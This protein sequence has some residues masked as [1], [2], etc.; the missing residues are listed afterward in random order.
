M[1]RQ[2]V[3]LGGGT[4]VIEGIQKGL[5]EKIKK[6]FTVGLN[7]SHHFFNSSFLMYVDETFANNQKY[8]LEKLPLV[9]G[10]EHSGVSIRPNTIELPGTTDYRRDCSK[11]V[12]RASL[13][14]IFALSFMIYALDEGDIFL[15]GYDYGAQKGSGKQGRS[16]DAH[17]KALTHWY[18]KGGLK[19]IYTGKPQQ[20]SHRGI[21]KVNW[22]EA[23]HVGE[24]G[25]L[26]MPRSEY[27][28]K[29][30]QG[31]KKV[32]IYNVSLDS[33]ISVFPKIGYDEFFNMLD[34]IDYDQTEIRKEM[35][36]K[37]VQ[38]RKRLGK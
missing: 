34:G 21:G 23:T 26:R 5:F 8:F 36:G 9:I 24:K 22:Y 19:S 18:Q 15:L 1:R 11:G 32:S 2:V 31:E 33:K 20:I 10:M 6:K 37:A 16:Y 28:F 27:E 4:S 3:I 38:L 12:Y 35:A 17:G 30:Y 7:Y 25:Q 14:G 13:A 29:V